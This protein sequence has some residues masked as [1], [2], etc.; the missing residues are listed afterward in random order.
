MTH[1]FTEIVPDD[2]KIAVFASGRGSNLEAILA[3]IREGRINGARI[4][5]VVS[6]NSGSGALETA[7]REGIPAL[8]ISGKHA[9]SESELDALVLD[10]LDRHRVN[11]I[12]LAGY[13]RKLSPAVVSRYRHRILNVHPALLPRF[14]GPGMYG[15]RVHRAVLESG[16]AMS[17]ATVHLVD[18]EYDRGPIVLQKSVP[19]LP[20]DTPE[21]LAA[22]VLEA[23]HEIYPEA[24]GL[25]AAGKVEIAG[26]AVRIV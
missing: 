12:A 5:V 22:R 16:E 18:E 7:R 1:N 20:G 8:H 19:V 21:T 25:F 14:G 17:G 10:A 13:M 15:E 2:L 11:F 26:D 4:A 6:N 9:S 24:I 3:A 23:E